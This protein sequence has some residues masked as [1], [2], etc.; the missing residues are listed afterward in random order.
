MAQPDPLAALAG[1]IARGRV[2]SGR[3]GG[4]R[5]YRSESL[6]A[7]FSPHVRRAAGPLAVVLIAS[8]ALTR[9][10]AT[11]TARIPRDNHA[12]ASHPRAQQNARRKRKPEYK[13]KPKRS[14]RRQRQRQTQRKNVQAGP[15]LARLCSAV[16]RRK[17]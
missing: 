17:D 4:K 6:H 15:P 8:H 2:G 9:A 12:S 10:S 13:R 3:R 7:P 5:L 11:R 16:S 14:P 1:A